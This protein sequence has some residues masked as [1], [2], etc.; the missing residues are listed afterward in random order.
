MLLWL[1]GLAATTALVGASYQWFDPPIAYFMHAH[2]GQGHL[3]I[4]DFLTG[5]P[6]PLIPAAIVL[7]IFEVFRILRRLPLTVHH[8]I[9]SACG[10]SILVAEIIK[11]QLKFVFGRSW[12]TSVGHHRPSLIGDGTYG[13]HWLHAGGAYQSFPSGHMGAACAMLSVLWVC[14]PRLRPL[15][16]AAALAI[17]TALIGGNYHFLGDVIAG[18][19]VGCT[20]GFAA[21]RIL[22]QWILGKN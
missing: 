3:G 8:K 1:V 15:W 21:T 14:Y 5:V 4:L 19:F 2:L 17:A 18:A 16:V 6:D 20:V 12:P 7:L 10:L 11:D 22:R 9:A 13:F